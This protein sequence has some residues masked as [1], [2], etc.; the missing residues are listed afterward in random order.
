MG[1]VLNIMHFVSKIMGFVLKTMNLVFNPT[2]AGVWFIKTERRRGQISV[3]ESWFPDREFWFPPENVDFMIKQS[4]A[5]KH[6]KA[7]EKVCRY[8]FSMM[9]ALYIHTGA[10]W[11]ENDGF[12]VTNDEFCIEND[13]CRYP[14]EELHSR[15]VKAEAEIGSLMVQTMIFIT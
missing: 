4:G 6:R 13:D 11:V 9:S 5:I 8:V 2:E 14:V 12:C 3:E 15:A 7:L 1:F 10:W